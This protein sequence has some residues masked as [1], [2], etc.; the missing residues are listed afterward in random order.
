MTSNHSFFS[1]S[2]LLKMREQLDHIFVGAG[3]AHLA[4]RRRDLVTVKTSK[5]RVESECALCS[6]T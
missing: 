4:I 2:D 5:Q 6:L 3:L 1:A